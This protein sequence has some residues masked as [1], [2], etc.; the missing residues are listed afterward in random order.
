MAAVA[1]ALPTM[2]KDARERLDS[3]LAGTGEA[4]GDHALYERFRTAVAAAQLAE[5]LP[6]EPIRKITTIKV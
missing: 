1:D 6:T 2:P 4:A 3:A 5:W